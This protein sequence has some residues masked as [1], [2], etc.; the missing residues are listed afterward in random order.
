M[1]VWRSRGAER[2]LT[3]Y[4]LLKIQDFH[5]IFRFNLII[6]SM[7]L[8]SLYIHAQ[9]SMLSWFTIGLTYGA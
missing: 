1:S 2:N 9:Q 4:D 6:K 5:E 3:L 8:Q 7:L